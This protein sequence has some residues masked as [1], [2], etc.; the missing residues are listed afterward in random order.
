VLFGEVL[1][2]PDTLAC[3]TPATYTLSGSRPD[4]YL[5][6]TVTLTLQGSQAGW[7]Y[8]L[9][10]DGRRIS[11]AA[12]GT[13]GGF[14]FRE[15]ATATGT[16]EYVVRTV[17]PTGVQCEM[18]ASSVQRITV[19]AA[20]PPP[21]GAASTLTWT[22]G[23]SALVWSDRIVVSACNKKVFTNSYIKP[24]CRSYTVDGALL[25]YYNWPYVNAEKS[26][27]CPSPWRVPTKDDFTALMNAATASTLSSAWGYGGY[28]NG[29]DLYGADSLAC[30]WS[31]MGYGSAGA[32]ELYYYS[33]DLYVDSTYKYYGQPVRCVMGKYE[34]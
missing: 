17:D 10:K 29:S 4:V 22:F 5:N 24:Q 28:T 23:S 27:M 3:I 14:L 30:Y 31:S 11:T 6:D 34:L 19:H 25:V 15:A 32:Y 8:L 13:G 9:Y 20:P 21:S 12:N 18:P 33:A 2:A 7:T 16:F 1:G 26:A